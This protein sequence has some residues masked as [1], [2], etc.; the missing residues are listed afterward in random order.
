MSQNARP[1]R[2][3]F[4][5]RDKIRIEPRPRPVPGFAQRRLGTVRDVKHV[6]HLRHQRDA[7]IDRDRVAAQAQ[8]LAAAIPMLIE[9]FDAVGD[10]LGETHFAGDI[11][12]AMTARLD[13][14]ARDLAAVL[15]DVDDGAEPFGEAGF[16]PG[17][18]EHE[19]QRLRQAAVDELEV[20]FEG[21]IVGRYSSQIRA[22]LLLQPRSF[23]SSA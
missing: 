18:T 19:A 23:S 10:R 1:R 12:A 17:M 5:G 15:E 3:A 16:Q 9:I 6:D 20:L 11:G 14:L 4:E 22:A 13:Q 8:R 21:E 7:R 2:D